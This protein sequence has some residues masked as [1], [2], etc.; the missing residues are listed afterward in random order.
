MLRAVLATGLLLSVTPA[1]AQTQAVRDNTQQASKSSKDGPDRVI[2]QT[3]QEIG[4]RIAT[5]K[6]CMT[7]QQWKDHEA[8]VRQQLDQQHTTTQSSGGPG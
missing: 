8:Q 4:S 2:C 1:M 3:Q 7:S 5:K 6:I